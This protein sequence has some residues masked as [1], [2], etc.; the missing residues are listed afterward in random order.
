MDTNTLIV[1]FVAVAAVA[2]VHAVIRAVFRAVRR[3]VSLVLSL[4]VV[5]GGGF[6]A[7]H[8]GILDALTSLAGR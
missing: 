3:V 1:I 2:I 6:V 8:S 4:A 5:S 7:D